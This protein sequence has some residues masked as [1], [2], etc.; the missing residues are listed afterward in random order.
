MLCL[1]C[2]YKSAFLL[3]FPVLKSSIRLNAQ[4][5]G[6]SLGFFFFYPL[7]SLSQQSEITYN[8]FPM[9]HHPLLLTFFLS[10]SPSPSFSLIPPLLLSQSVSSD[11]PGF[12][13][14]KR[15]PFRTEHLFIQSQYCSHSSN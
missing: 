3:T 6:S 9:L 2:K 7:S 8:A 4:R 12:C 13:E 15:A 10:F 14:Q 5:L 1:R 11:M